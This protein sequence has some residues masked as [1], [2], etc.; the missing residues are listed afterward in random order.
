[1]LK[2]ILFR[3]RFT[4]HNIIGHPVMEILTLLGLA[5]FGEWVHATTLPGKTLKDK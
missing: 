2:K 3:F 4:I 5:R 1:V